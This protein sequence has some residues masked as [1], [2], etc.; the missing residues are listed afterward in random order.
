MLCAGI[1]SKLDYIKGLHVETIWLGAFYKSPL[2]DY[3]Y[4][5]SDYR[6]VDGRYGS[7]EDFDGLLEQIHAEGKY[8]DI[9]CM[10]YLGYY[11]Y[12]IFIM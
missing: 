10:Y 3:G 6:D 9:L 12:I 2:E 1:K 5:V 11:L 4:D 8:S 7:L